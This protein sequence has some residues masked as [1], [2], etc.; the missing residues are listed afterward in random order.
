[1][2]FIR[3]PF[4]EA[5]LQPN[6]MLTHHRAGADKQIEAIPGTEV[7]DFCSLPEPYK[8]YGCGNATMNVLPVFDPATRAVGPEE[9]VSTDEW[10]A[11]KECA[12]FIDRQMPKDLAE[13]SA[14]RFVEVH[15]DEHP[16]LRQMPKARLR[17]EFL[18]TQAAFWRNRR[19][20]EDRLWSPRGHGGPRRGHG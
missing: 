17:R 10:L 7:C 8:L 14:R 2:P 5:D 15:A 3:K 16:Q 1:M 6:Q 13:R 20:S 11:C 9:H 12:F 19:P 4:G 18:G